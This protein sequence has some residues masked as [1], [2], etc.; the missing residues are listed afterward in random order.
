MCGT[1]NDLPLDNGTISSCDLITGGAIGVPNSPTFLSFL[2]LSAGLILLTVFSIVSLKKQLM[3]VK[4][5]SIM[6]IIV[7]FALLI[8]TLIISAY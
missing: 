7:T 2:F 1:Y 4:D 6:F 8:A 3:T 5:I